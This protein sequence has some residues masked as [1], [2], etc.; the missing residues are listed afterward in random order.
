[1]GGRLVVV[2]SPGD[3]RLLALTRAMERVPGAT[4]VVV[5]WGDALRD[6]ALAGRHAIT[7]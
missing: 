6:P 5:P 2:A 7:T 4:L 3:K 1:M